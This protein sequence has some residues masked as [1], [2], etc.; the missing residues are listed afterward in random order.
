M[1][2]ILFLNLIL[3]EHAILQSERLNCNSDPLPHI[4]WLLQSLSTQQQQRESE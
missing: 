1:M 3:I 4:S 2:I